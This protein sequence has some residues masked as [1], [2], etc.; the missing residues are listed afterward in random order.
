MSPEFAAIATLVGVAVVLAGAIALVVLGWKFRQPEIDQ[1]EA[2]LA[3]TRASLQEERR[4]NLARA[5]G[6]QDDL[7]QDRALSDDHA[8]GDV[9]RVLEH[10][11][12]RR[13]DSATDEQGSETDAGDSQDA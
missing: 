7:L 11:P 12:K 5:K 10:F 1:L 3:V 6:A 9:D 13:S 2:D 8:T 4:R